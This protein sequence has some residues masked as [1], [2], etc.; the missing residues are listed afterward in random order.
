MSAWGDM[1][2][3]AWLSDVRFT[4][5]SGHQATIAACPFGAKP[6]VPGAIQ[7][8]RRLATAATAGL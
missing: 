4:S 1:D 2:I 3:S 8:L 6:E 7:L 5:R